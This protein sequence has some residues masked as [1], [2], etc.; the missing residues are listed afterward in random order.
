MILHRF[1]IYLVFVVALVAGPAVAQDKLPNLTELFTRGEGD[2][3]TY[4]IPAVIATKKGSLLVF[5]EGRKSGGGDAGNIDLLVIRSTDNGKTWSQPIVVWDNGAN[6]CGNPAPVVDQE[7]G[8]IWLPM[9]WN[10][11]SDHER[12]IMA[13]KSKHPRDVYLTH[14]KDDGV[15]WALPKKV[16]ESTRQDHW[17]WYA[18]GPGNAIQLTR[19]SHKGRLVIPCNHSDHRDAEK[20]PYRSHVI[21]SDDHGS[22]WRIGGVH[23][24]KTNESAV[25]ELV[26]GSVMQAMRSYHGKNKR[27]MSVSNDGGQTWGE[28]YLDETLDTPVCQASILRAT[29]PEDGK[30]RILFSSPRGSKRQDLHVWVSHDEGKT[31]PISKRIYQGG[32]AYSNL[33]MMPDGRVGVVFERDGYARISLAVFD[34]AWLESQ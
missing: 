20:H 4:R 6:T 26:D 7:T 17:R 33:V 28:L 18:T 5:C 21:F 10:L 14:S 19:G 30:S 12:D 2:Y 29:W 1:A 31:W 23:D 13:G 24:E 16:S 22:T 9:T 11:G 25:V 32:S 34:W 8:T 27:A 3:H 15:T